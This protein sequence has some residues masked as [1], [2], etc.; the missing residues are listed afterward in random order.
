MPVMVVLVRAA[1]VYA[2]SVIDHAAIPLRIEIPHVAQRGNRVMLEAFV[3]SRRI[4]N[5]GY[6][7][8]LRSCAIH[9]WNHPV[10]ESDK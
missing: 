6:W 4:D 8:S 5:L 9:E 7:F 1:A 10:T 2:D 3:A